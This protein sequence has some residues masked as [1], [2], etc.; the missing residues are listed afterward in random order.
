[1]GQRRASRHRRR[2]GVL[3]RTLRM[4][5]H[6]RYAARH[7]RPVRHREARRPRRRRHRRTRQHRGRVLGVE[8]LRCGGRRRRRRRPDRGGGRARAGRTV[9][10]RGGRPVDDLRRSVGRAVPGLAG[11]A[12]AGCPGR[13]HAGGMELQRPAGRRSGGIG[14][15]LHA[16]V[17]V[18]HR[19]HRL[20]D[21][22][23]PTGDTAIT[24]RPRP[25]PISMHV[26]RTSWSRP[27][28]PTPSAGS[29]R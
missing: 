3:R 9:R 6:R 18:V 7:S 19:R 12:A 8:H 20:R 22:D 21:H 27:A 23:P 28:S 10:C 5:V 17:R 24:L 11:P 1:M 4:D 14:G 26:R 2:A 25:I 29:P 13:Q 16:G 15:V